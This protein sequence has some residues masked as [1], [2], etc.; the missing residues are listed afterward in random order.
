MQKYIDNAVEQFRA[1][2]TEQLARQNR[3]EAG[4]QAKDFANLPHITIGICGGDGIGPRITASARRVLEYLLAD[5]V[6]AGKVEFRDIE[7]L[8]IENR[9]AHNQAIPDDVMQELYK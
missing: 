4:E 2:I 3:M 5:E 8:T 9:A 6:A 7:G 1:L